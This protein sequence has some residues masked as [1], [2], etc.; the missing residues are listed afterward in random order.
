M[1]VGPSPAVC[2][3]VEPVKT[4][5]RAH[6]NGDMSV[7]C[8]RKEGEWLECLNAAILV[9]MIGGSSIFD[10]GCGGDIRW[11]GE[12]D[13]RS[14]STRMTTLPPTLSRTICR[15]HVRRNR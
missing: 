1:R 15:M 4:R 13:P 2:S 5:S 7:P 12:K 14:W 11:R 3:S 6:A 10:A 8:G 9:L